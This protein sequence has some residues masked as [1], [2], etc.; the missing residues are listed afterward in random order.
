MYELVIQNPKLIIIDDTENEI[1]SV[2][3]I[4]NFSRYN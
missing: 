1:V 2:L 3:N 4:Y